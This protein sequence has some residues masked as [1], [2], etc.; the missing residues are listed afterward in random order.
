MKVNVDNQKTAKKYQHDLSHDVSTT[1]DFGHVQP[2]MCR[3]ISGNST[4]QLNISQ[5]VRMQRLL[6]PVFGR[7]TLN[8][9]NV[10]VPIESVFHPYASLRSQQ[11]YMGANNTYIPNQVITISPFYLNFVCKMWSSVSILDLGII[12]TETGPVE[13]GMSVSFYTPNASAVAYNTNLHNEVWQTYLDSYTDIYPS[14]MSL[15]SGDVSF[16]TNETS[17]DAE[18]VDRYDW[19]DTINY[20]GSMYLVCGRYSVAASNLR[21]VL[22][23]L[24]YKLVD[25]KEEVSALPIFAYYKAWF[26]LFAPQREITWKD[27]ACAGIQEWME[28]YGIFSF[29][30]SGIYSANASKVYDFFVELV[31]TYYTCDPDFVSSHITGQRIS[32]VAEQNFY[33]QNQFSS[34]ISVGIGQESYNDGVSFS[35]DSGE[36]ILSD[37]LSPQSLNILQQMYHRINAKTAIG[38]RIR[39]YLK[40]QLGVDYLNEDESYWIGSQKIDLNV[41]PVFSQA[42]TTEGYLGEFAG[43]GIGSSQN[44][45]QRWKYEAKVDGYWI[46]LAAIVPDSRFAQGM[47]MTLKHV[48]NMDFYDP[49]FDSITLLPTEKKYIFCE[50]QLGHRN[51]P[52]YQPW[53]DSFGNIPNYMEYCVAQNIL[54]GDMS[55]RSTRASYLPFTLDK[56]LPY[57]QSHE[58]NGSTTISS[59][60]AS[61]IVNSTL[62]RYIGI[63]RWLG[64]YNRIFTNSG[65]VNTT[66]ITAPYYASLMSELPLDDN[67]LSH[68]Y[69]NMTVWSTKLPVRDSFQTGVFDKDSLTIEKA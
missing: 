58:A 16:P 34:T 8:T 52:T 63:Y 18:N 7:M 45:E 29:A 53:S 42:E 47:D 54:N 10:F 35:S 60:S 69:F 39:E 65:D 19:M 21:K 6:R 36:N 38:G 12:G 67:F 59:T 13:S 68:N 50:D 43:A 5:I 1:F 46:T 44:R 24:G 27:T 25:D 14:F 9:Y 33:Y 62:W 51:L 66:E 55:K 49:K 17:E 30:N 22:Y 56:L 41:S 23:G 32:N 15:F 20:D 40:S 48:G 37:N 64:Q 31:K 11:T 4:A 2:L 61:L 26:D 3:E 28:Q 57:T